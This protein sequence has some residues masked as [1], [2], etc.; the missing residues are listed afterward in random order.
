MRLVIFNAG[1]DTAGVGIS[2]KKAFDRYA[3]G[4][5][6]RSICRDETYLGYEVDI[7]WPIEEPSARQTLDVIRL[8]RSAHVIHAMDGAHGMRP[9]RPRLRP[10]QKVVV[11]HLGSRYRSDPDLAHERSQLYHATEVTDSIDLVSPEVGFLPTAIDTEALWELRQRA[12]QPTKRLRIAHAPT[13]R[14]Y[15]STAQIVKAVESLQDRYPLDFDLIEGVG[16]AECLQRKAQADIFVDQLT[17]GFGVNNIECWSMGIPV[18]SGL[19]AKPE[20]RDLALSMFGQLP[21]ADATEATLESVIEH[22]VRS[23]QWRSE[24]GQRGRQ[25]AERWHSQRSVVEQTQAVYARAAAIG[26]SHSIDRA[27]ARKN[28]QQSSPSSIPAG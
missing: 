16:N 8:M 14:D 27:L 18:V 10:H 7:L 4:W 24:L 6:T 19:T 12:Y 26:T 9:F 22:L 11:Q 2:L 13:S 3:A 23:P 21:W 5:E 28:A 17:L 20:A 25:H 1:P 15:K